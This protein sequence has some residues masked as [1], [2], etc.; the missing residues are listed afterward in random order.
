MRRVAP[1]SAGWYAAVSGRQPSA[2]PVGT[3]TGNE[4]RWASSIAGDGSITTGSSPPPSRKIATIT[5]TGIKRT[6]RDITRSRMLRDDLV[7]AGVSVTSPSWPTTSA[8]PY[9]GPARRRYSG[10]GGA[11]APAGPVFLRRRSAAAPDLSGFSY[12]SLAYDVPLGVGGR[13]SQWQSPRPS[14]QARVTAYRE[15]ADDV[16]TPP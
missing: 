12:P 2:R 8:A 7:G 1:S 9:T 13:L 14:P 15:E 6:M 5:A 10:R 4:A 11:V 16:R 3:A